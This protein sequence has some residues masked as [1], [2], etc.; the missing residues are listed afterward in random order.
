MW[1]NPCC[2][3][4]RVGETI[5]FSHCPPLLRKQKGR[6]EEHQRNWLFIIILFLWKTGSTHTEASQAS[7]NQGTC[8]QAPMCY[9]SGHQSIHQRWQTLSLINR[10]AFHLYLEPKGLDR[11]SHKLNLATVAIPSISQTLEQP[12]GIIEFTGTYIGNRCHQIK[13]AQ[14]QRKEL[15]TIYAQFLEIYKAGVTAKTFT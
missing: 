1:Q 2:S 8:I 10:K 14:M 11:S 5:T 9:P 6:K 12:C 13:P 3:R 7:W 4:A 15:D